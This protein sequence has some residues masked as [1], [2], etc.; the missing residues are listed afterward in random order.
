MNRT[1]PAPKPVGMFWPVMLGCHVPGPDVPYRREMTVNYPD[2][3]VVDTQRDRGLLGH[4]AKALYEKVKKRRLMDLDDDIR[5]K[6]GLTREPGRETQREG[7]NYDKMLGV[8]MKA[9]GIPGEKQG[10]DEVPFERFAE[11]LTWRGAT[12]NRP[13]M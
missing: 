2:G 3:H 6:L 4:D 8:M 1:I 5:K 10:Q 12:Q 9:L 13:V 11:D 7:K